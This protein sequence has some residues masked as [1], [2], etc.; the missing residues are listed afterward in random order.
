M[1]LAEVKAHRTAV[2]QTLNHVVCAGWDAGG[3]RRRLFGVYA[4]GQERTRECADGSGDSVMGEWVGDTVGACGGRNA[5]CGGKKA[6]WSQRAPFQ[7][8]GM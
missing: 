2:Q 7:R 5:D 8:K 1:R 6:R 4:G 3:T